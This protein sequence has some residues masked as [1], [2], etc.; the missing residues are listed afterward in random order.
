M[1]CSVPKKELRNIDHSCSVAYTS[2]KSESENVRRGPGGVGEGRSENVT[3]P[4][5]EIAQIKAKDRG[6]RTIPQDLR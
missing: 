1:V 2:P 6:A 3:P 5:E 4:P